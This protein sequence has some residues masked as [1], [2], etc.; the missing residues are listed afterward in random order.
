MAILNGGIEVLEM[1]MTRVSFMKR[2]AIGM[3]ATWFVVAVAVPS[4]SAVCTV[5]S[6]EALTQRITFDCDP[7][8]CPKGR[9]GF[10]RCVKKILRASEAAGTVECN[11]ILSDAYL[12]AIYC[13]PN[14]NAVP[15]HVTTPTAVERC[16]IVPDPAR[17]RAPRNGAACMSSISC[18]ESCN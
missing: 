7:Y 13:N 3:V 1:V 6:L 14:A 8:G 18:A 5:R 11:P 9:G 2:A 16:R 15:C 17:C 10:V 12:K 4:A